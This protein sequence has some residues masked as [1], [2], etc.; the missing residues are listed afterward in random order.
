MGRSIGKYLHRAAAI[1]LSV[2]IMAGVLPLSS[3]AEDTDRRFANFTGWSLESTGLDELQPAAGRTGTCAQ[4]VKAGA[5][6]SALCSDRIKVTSGATYKA[7]VFLKMDTADT[8]Y[9]ALEI[10]AF[11]DAEGK[12]PVGT[13][14]ILATL[15]AAAEFTEVSG[16]YTVPD[17]ALYLTVRVL[18]GNDESARGDVYMAD[19]A[20]VYAYTAA[21]PLYDGYTGGQWY[22]LG[23]KN[24]S[25]KYAETVDE[26]CQDAGSLRFVNGS[27]EGDMPIALETAGVTA[28]EYTLS[29]YIRG[30]VS[31]AGEFRIFEQGH[32][33]AKVLISEQTTYGEWTKIE[34]PM[35]VYADRSDAPSSPVFLL[36]FGQ[37]SGASDLY[38]DNI[39][40]VNKQTGADILAGKGGFCLGADR[41]LN[42]ASNL[43]P[44]GEFED[45]VYTYLPLDA[46]NGT[47][48]GAD[49][50]EAR[51]DWTLSDNATGD[52]LS[53]EQDGAHGKFL[54]MTKG[55][56]AEAGA[57]WV[58]LASP[59]IAVGGGASYE[60]SVELR[61]EG[62]KPYYIVTGYFF[63]NDGRSP[64]SFETGVM[65]DAP[66][67]W[68]GASARLTAP[69]GAATVQ[70]R[71]VFQGAAG[72]TLYVDN[73]ALR[74]VT[75]TPSMADWDYAGF[76]Q[77]PNVDGVSDLTLESEGYTDAGAVHFIQ[78]YP[79]NAGAGREPSIANLGKNW[80]A[81]QTYVFSAWLK[82]DTCSAGDPAKIELVWGQAS[83]TDTQSAVRELRI[84]SAGWT[85]I[86]C[87]FQVNTPGWFPIRVYT[88]QYTGADFYLDNVSVHVK[89]DAAETNV[90]TN[91]GFCGGGVP[92][93]DRNL[94]TDGG[95]EQAATL[96]IPGWSVSGGAAYT[97]DGRLITLRAGASLRSYRYD[98]KG[99]DIY[100]VSYT[101][102]DG[103]LSFEFDDGRQQALSGN[104]GYFIVPAG[105]A[106]IRVRYAADS[107]GA[108]ISRISLR[109]EEH[110][111]NFNFELKDPGGAGPMNWLGYCTGK[112]G[113][114]LLQFG[115][116]EGVDGSHAMKI[117]AAKDNEGSYVAY[118]IRREVKPSTV[119]DLTFQGKYTGADVAAFPLVRQYTA[120]GAETTAASSY[121]WLSG[122]AS[123]DGGGTW[124][125]Y[126]AD[127]STSADAAFI[128]IRFEVRA[129][130]AGASFLFDNI[131]YEELGSAT[132]LNF[133]FEKGAG[134][135][136]P[137]NWTTYERREKPD[138]PGEYEEGGFGG[139]TV[140]KADGASA[141]GSA[142]AVLRKN[143]T[144]PVELYF[145]SGVMEAEP[146]TYYTFAYDAMIRDAKKNG[147][148]IFIRQ[149]KDSAGTNVDDDA[150]TYL[151]LTSAYAYG[152]FDW[153]ECG[154][155]FRT[156]ADCRYLQLMFVMTGEEPSTVWLDN[157]S[158]TKTEEI[159]DVNLDFEY[160]VGGKPVN[161]STTTS[162]GVFGVSVNSD[163]FY[164]GKQ[165]VFLQ[166]A[167]SEINY[168]TLETDRYIRVN[169][170]DEVEFAIHM[171]SRNSVGGSFA[172]VIHGLDEDGNVMQ[173]WHGQ[174]RVLNT[175]GE[176]SGWDTY[177]LMYT[178][179]KSVRQVK[180]VLRLGGK[181]ADVFVDAIEYYNY[182]QSGGVVY[183]E[184]FAGPSSNGMFGGWKRE[185]AAGSPVFGTGGE[186]SIAGQA[187]DSGGIY[188]DLYT[189]KTDCVYTVKA[190]Y[191]TEGTAEG[192]LIL[193]AR[194]WLDKPTR[195]V[196]SQELSSGGSVAE[197][198]T[199]FT[200]VSASAYRLY[201]EKTGG[202][203]T[204][205]LQNVILRQTGEPSREVGW[206][207]S[208]I[209]HPDDYDSLLTHE[210]NDRYYYTRQELYLDS[211]VKT[212]QIQ[213]AVD[214]KY[215]LFVN[216][217]LAYEETR[218]GDTW[219]LPGLFDITEHLQKGKNV[220]AVEM[221][222][223]VYAY[224]V[225]YDGIIKMEND[226]VRRFYSNESVFI[227]R[228]KSGEKGTPDP[229]WSKQDAQTF[230][231]PDYDM[232]ACSAWIPAEVYCKVGG[233]SWG[234]IDFDNTEYSDYKLE[235]NRFVFPKDTV[236]AGDSVTVEAT[237]KIR[238]KLPAANSFPVYFWK[239]NSTS[240]ICSGNIILADGKTT[241]SWPVGREF[242]ARF[243]MKVPDFLAQGSYMVQ[244]DNTV[245]IVSDYYIGNKVG[246]LKVAQPERKLTTTSEVKMA[247]GRPTYFVNGVA[248]A[249]IW[250]AR[251]ERDSQYDAS[252]IAKYADI[253]VDTIVPYILPRETLGE[254]WMPDGSLN[255]ATIDTQI[256][257]TL[258]GNPEA[259]LQVAID[260]TP[261]QWWLDA[262]PEECV[263][264]SNGKLSKESFSSEKWK[265]ETGE[266][267]IRIIHYLMEQPY[268]NNI[269]GIKIT[270][271][272][273]Y[274]W[275]WWGMNG[276][277]TVVG[278]FSSAGL[279][280]YRGWLRNKYK[281]D[282]ALQ[283]AWGDPRVTMATA[284]VPAIEARSESEYGSILHAQN[285]PDVIDYEL[286]MAD[287]KTDAILYFA[288]LVKEAVDDRIVVGT[289]AGYLLNCTTYE[290]GTS[291]AQV[292]LER[293]LESD[294]IDYVKCP[295]LYGEREIGTSGDYMGPVDSVTAHGKLYVAEDDDRLNLLR[296]DLAQDSRASVG[297]TRTT[298]QSVETIKRN[299]AYALSK[300]QTLDFYNLGGGYFDDEQYYGVISQ[301]MQEMTLAQGLERQSVSDVAVFMDGQSAAYFPYTGAD[302][303]NELL[304]KS[305]LMQQRAE[306]YNIGAPFNTYLL[307]D[308]AKGLVPEH[309]I[310]IFLSTTQMTREE[311]TAIE[312][313]LK[314]N[315]NLLVFIFLSGIADGKTT[316]V[317]LLS[318][319][320]GMD[321]EVV[322]TERKQVGTVLVEN[323]DHWLTQGLA[324]VTYGAAE[325][326]TLSP[327]IAV[328]DP[329]ATDI[330]YH[331]TAGL[332]GRHVGLAVKEITNAD[333]SKWTSVYS[334]VPA[335]PTALIRNMLRHEGCHIYDD[336][337]SD[338]VYADG[339][340]VAVHSLFGGERTI[341]L[342]KN[343]TVYDVFNRK[344]IAA[345][346]NAFTVA[347]DGP[348]TRLF[349]LSK[350]DTVQ[351]Y[352]TRTKGGRVSPEGLTE[353]EPGGELT[354]T[355]Q[356][357]EGYRLN[358]L[359]IDGIKTTV[360]G[361][362]YTFRN[363]QESHTVV[364][365]YTP[366]YEKPPVEEPDK[367]DEPDISGGEPGSR[368]GDSSAPSTDNKVDG[369]PNEP[370]QSGSPESG[371]EE[372]PESGAP[373]ASGG[374]RPVIQDKTTYREETVLNWPAIIGLIVGCVAG[375]GAA[376]TVAI[377]LL[378]RRKKQRESKE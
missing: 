277:N 111:E 254:L 179:P 90:L 186:A 336:N 31:T 38:V 64:Q 370:V 27:P 264:L 275:Q 49:N 278:D 295:W 344:I 372:N 330:A 159:E 20:Y 121:I 371:P 325:Y 137:L 196:V 223:D 253:G 140:Y 82:G 128:E 185:T 324:D 76:Y 218:T 376:V 287:M 100:H 151:W 363:L 207:G 228:E 337:S 360:Q 259:Y 320:T 69:E 33:A 63:F 216:G 115:E 261:P 183:A 84:N 119:Y 102:S 11:E 215:K 262:N 139:Y 367:P 40:L 242:T 353:K 319:V 209:V 157:V 249:P 45:I 46:F 190:S 268:A 125:S 267:V 163:V 313:Q 217:E 59:L 43:L 270:G 233:G 304:F 130:T 315:G 1:L 260:T 306:L 355:F 356:A 378:K 3:Y 285:S 327:V 169:P 323:Y 97:E 77:D 252:W 351:V 92:D 373:D 301:M 131:S 214:D 124:N 147:L 28:G 348:E 305:V 234:L 274:E 103:T 374:Q 303:A 12:R 34:K 375:A 357:E 368:P 101:G 26:G 146:D 60:F 177:N 98:V 56:S 42:T 198:E 53:V 167:Y 247:G 91:G 342:P 117:T 331:N 298:K 95:F 354:F 149:Y 176:L 199:S 86:T 175:S 17:R 239:R 194:N 24:T 248:T 78:K 32:D 251:P 309:K 141:D 70:I 346:T 245:A 345:D 334:G 212:A 80:T 29:L 246:N 240:K 10:Q 307:D 72:D 112:E 44:N 57:G 25:A 7:G 220:I 35:T 349:R 122:I 180:L 352:V 222:N 311:R 230:M 294:A 2:T 200:A 364:A 316:D 258:A 241:D 224:G 237:L 58:S 145:K 266:I 104:T 154:G 36:F 160:A 335:V 109:L 173:Y 243:T 366:V 54:R 232:A 155:S 203:G 238:E 299:F 118:S 142:A 293:I 161:W 50:G 18:M 202:D 85:R 292:A 120:S 210:H 308:L 289:Y 296:L 317:S 229:A 52:T 152:S 123:T 4:V 288:E 257:G 13:G 341:H 182:T 193:E 235:S 106:Y 192:R 205:C 231:N 283:A 271:G 143:G 302:T 321:L 88:S 133:D 172:A 171:R 280:A 113:D 110:P 329:E 284:E 312:K 361:D 286:F 19:N 153:R 339:N 219:S 265:K 250:F 314:K 358:Y 213:I 96:T 79:E 51:L 195:T 256:L 333:G 273:T 359:L 310:N 15:S 134:G 138:R 369:A 6:K 365:R 136:I 168:S 156:A 127:F 204:V 74:P 236:Y 350:P 73:A 189:L 148:R 116:G 21:M 201:F 300:G 377:L 108:S 8:G 318:E 221:Y 55:A 181:Q 263:K 107:E 67:G 61:G 158:F 23:W 65:G 93:A 66:A 9:A 338:V 165:S 68:T 48:E 291:T 297:W 37:Y 255:T 16:D 170:G 150:Q 269:A 22:R 114:Y 332:S 71:L 135:R 162:D 89:G 81:G 362:S 290:F 83:W 99:G 279:T 178:V 187:A 166:K 282:A 144:E 14:T 326:H 41:V 347:L 225:L 227:A 132:D 62:T 191:R 87:E 206:V 211:E 30:H 184:D 322:S 39:S 94:I 272:T 164:R 5:G 174:E 197:L 343:C 244:F 126:S 47:F 340:Y 105:A 129:K 188:T 226:S 208:W 281:T 328:R 276:N 75:A